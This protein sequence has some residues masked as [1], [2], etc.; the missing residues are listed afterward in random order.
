LVAGS[1]TAV[2]NSAPDL[3]PQYFARLVRNVK[4]APSPEWMQRR[5]LDLNSL[6]GNRQR[7]E[8]QG[9]GLGSVFF[10]FIPLPNIPLP[11]KSQCQ[12]TVQF[13]SSLWMPPPPLETPDPGREDDE[14]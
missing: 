13:K 6:L 7:N 11:S 10:V 14:E 4:V 9:N 8:R 5:G 12:F 3:C 2:E 1:L